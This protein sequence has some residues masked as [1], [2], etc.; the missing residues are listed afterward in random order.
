MTSIIDLSAQTLGGIY[1]FCSMRDLAMMICLHP[2]LACG[3]GEIHVFSAAV[4]SSRN[5]RIATRQM[6]RFSSINKFELHI[7]NYGDGEKHSPAAMLKPTLKR[8]V[9]IDR[10]NT[11]ITGDVKEANKQSLFRPS[12]DPGHFDLSQTC[13]YLESLKVLGQSISNLV[14]IQS[15]S[16]TLTQL[17]IPRALLSVDDLVHLPPNLTDLNAPFISENVSEYHLPKSLTQIKTSISHVG[18][19]R[20]EHFYDI[21]FPGLELLNSFIFTEEPLTKASVTALP[22]SLTHLKISFAEDSLHHSLTHLSQLQS[23][24]IT[25][26]LILQYDDIAFTGLPQSLKTLKC[27]QW[28]SGNHFSDLP[29]GLTHLYAKSSS[30]RRY[31]ELNPMEL[32]HLPKN[33]KKCEL[34]PF[35]T[36]FPTHPPTQILKESIVAHLPITLTSL[37]MKSFYDKIELDFS[38]AICLSHFVLETMRDGQYAP[39]IRRLPPSV[40]HLELGLPHTQEWKDTDARLPPNLK[41]AVFSVEESIYGHP[42]YGQDEVDTLYWNPSDLPQGLEQ[43]DL[44]GIFVKINDFGLLPSQ[45]RHLS[46]SFEYALKMD[47]QT[48][49]DQFSQLPRTLETINLGTNRFENF[50]ALLSLPRF[51]PNLIKLRL[52]GLHKPLQDSALA[53]LPHSLSEL[54]AFP[55]SFTKE[56]IL[57]HAPPAIREDLLAQLP[58]PWANMGINAELSFPS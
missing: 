53:C 16:S 39:L 6:A 33:L 17:I 35:F 47:A 11:R 26:P 15:P 54:S 1:E 8:L 37:R 2:S 41:I 18:R 56:G 36:H 45:L 57:L 58:Q 46:L 10:T 20:L 22:S 9:M 21:R 14:L 7:S 51:P 4:A 55:T 3:L 27:P 52:F 34:N 38:A 25:T 5:E 30:K 28:P 44:E 19:H 29:D 24:T 49:A 40:T 31:S 42:G 43:L 50:D 23:L 32:A 13:P 12:D 48:L